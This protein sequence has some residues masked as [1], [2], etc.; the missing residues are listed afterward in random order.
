MSTAQAVETTVV[1]FQSSEFSI[2]GERFEFGAHVQ[3]MLL[4]LAQDATIG[5]RICGTDK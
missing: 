4:I 2:I 1:R 3:L 5:T